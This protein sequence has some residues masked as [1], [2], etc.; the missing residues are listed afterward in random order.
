M[1]VINLLAAPGTGK[2][3]TGQ[4]LS[5]MLSIADYKVEYIPEFAKFAT[6]SNNQAAL[7][8]QIYMFAKQE[9]RLHVL[10][11]AGLDF[12]IM[13][14]PLPVA[15]LFQPEKYYTAYE[16]L[17]MEVFGSYE[18]I[19]FFLRRNS[20]LAYKKVGRT[21]SLAEANALELRLRGIL[22]KHQ[23]PYLDVNVD[24]SLASRLFQ[25]ITGEAPPHLHVG[26]GA[27][28]TFYDRLR[29]AWH[30]WHV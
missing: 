16:P 19:N 29:S 13:D 10:R 3:T 25:H 14:G 12:V 26:G 18:N 27:P 23:V 24:K 7:S 21:E 11:N 28:K 2:S 17:V 8:D 9:N 30:A 1:K 15:L 22:S 20:A 6:F 5:G 4:I